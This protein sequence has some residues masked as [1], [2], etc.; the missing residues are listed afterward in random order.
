M[1]TL[2]RIT[3]RIPVMLAAIALVVAMGGEWTTSASAAP[4]VLAKSTSPPS[5]P[6]PGDDP[7][8]RAAGR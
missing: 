7:D 8:P 3:S 4:T 6:S 1:T 5:S 2:T